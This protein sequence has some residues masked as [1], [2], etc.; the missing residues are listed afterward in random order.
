[1]ARTNAVH[2]V[3]CSVSVTAVTPPGYMTTGQVTTLCP[4]GF[5]R[6][7]WGAPASSSSCTACG[8]GIAS[9]PNDQF[10]VYNITT[11]E[12]TSMQ[13]IRGNSKSCCKSLGLV[14]SDASD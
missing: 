14:G 12:L 5:Y 2:V 11:N 7:G 3:F 6:E 9:E 10:A 1:M 13:D 4:S 8:S